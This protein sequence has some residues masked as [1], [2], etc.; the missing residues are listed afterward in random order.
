MQARR[1]EV[2]LKLIVPSDF[3]V[4]PLEDGKTG[5]ASA[6]EEAPQQLNATYFD[7]PDMRLMRHG[8]T[9]RYR[10]GEG[11]GSLWTLKLPANGDLAR[12]SELEFAGEPDQPPAEARNLLF[13][14]LTDGPLGPTAEIRTKRRRWS[15]AN[16]SGE[17]LAELVDDRVSIVDGEKV[18]GR[19]R[20]IEIEA[21]NIDRKGLERIATRMR[22]A[23]A[24]PEQ[25]SKAN[26]AME[27][28]HKLAS[29]NGHHVSPKDDA[30]E[31]VGPSLEGALRRLLSFDPYARLGDPEGVHQ[32]RVA[33]RRLRSVIRTFA[34]LCDPA[35][36]QPV[37]EDLRWLGGV[38]GEVRDLDVL[39]ARLR[40]DSGEDAAPFIEALTPRRENA[41]AALKEA[42]N[43]DRYVAFIQ[44]V[45]D[46]TQDEALVTEL[47]GKAREVLPELVWRIWKKLRIA[48]RALTPESE[49]ADFH[50][51]RI[52]AKRARYSAETIA[53]YMPSKQ[54][55][56]VEDFAEGAESVQNILGEHQDA[57]FARNVIREIAADRPHDVAI[58]SRVGTLVE[59]QKAIAEDRRSR[60]FDEWKRLDRKQNTKWGK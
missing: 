25:R 35:K 43:S 19:F 27:V 31:A 4:P 2:E 11:N 1:N 46:L 41:R 8:I 37:V 51:V 60:F 9:L 34:P 32:L 50:R 20:E 16:E 49:E 3:E 53:D 48:G 10:T 15:L 14:F 39:E 56:Q 40:E 45:T 54:K 28:L 22:K 42:L 38:L 33:A 52:L 23:G 6:A 21:E 26:R 24:K 12:R 17:K 59:R 47:S 30:G 18:K 5:V 44:R 57:N 55:K 58:S 7:T 29:Q 13:A 36:I